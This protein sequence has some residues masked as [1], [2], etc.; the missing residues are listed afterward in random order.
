V[1]DEVRERAV[2][3]A[4]PGVIGHWGDEWSRNA[5]GGGVGPLAVIF[6]L[7]ALSSLAPGCGSSQSDSVAQVVQ[8]ATAAA[9]AGRSGVACQYVTK[10]GKARLVRAFSGVFNTATGH[11][12]PT[13]KT[14]E[15]VL[16]YELR[17]APATMRDIKE[18]KVGPVRVSGSTATTT[19]T[20]RGG[21]SGRIELRKIHGQ[22][23]L[24][25]S[26]SLPRGS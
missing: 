5:P 10:E 20:D 13:F 17:Q 15:E 22:W 6:A 1:A 4:T 21:L 11:R 25:D 9:A 2:T 19:L 14:C 23:K 24:D 8:K 16:A 7:V 12:G 26:D 18:A 3:V